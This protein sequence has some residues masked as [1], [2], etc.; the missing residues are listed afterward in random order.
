MNNK[1]VSI[2]FEHATSIKGTVCSVGIV[3]FENGEVIDEFYSLV[4][5]P[6]N[7]YNQYTILKHNITP[8]HTINSPLFI[9]IYP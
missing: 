5:P 6:N 1:F 7:E 3:V 4:K 2:D 8:E 9:E